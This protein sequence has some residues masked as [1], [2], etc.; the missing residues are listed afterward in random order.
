MKYVFYILLFLMS[1]QAIYSQQKVIIPD[2][3]MSW[4]YAPEEYRPGKVPHYKKAA[5]DPICIGLAE[6]HKRKLIRSFN[7]LLKMDVRQSG[8]IKIYFL[9]LESGE[10]KT[11]RIGT[12]DIALKEDD[13]HA[14]SA[15]V[16]SFEKCV[17]ARHEG[18]I[19]NSE[20][21]I[22]FTIK[23]GF[24]SDYNLKRITTSE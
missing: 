4:K 10:I 21:I 12:K 5:V 16:N 18:A 8:Y 15:E 23:R 14:L 22:Y 13:Y 1:T 7:D 17:P 9:I 11:T 24:I 2:S 6:G 3:I 20:G 19:V